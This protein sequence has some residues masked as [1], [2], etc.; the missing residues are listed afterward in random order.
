MS[1][2]LKGR[3]EGEGRCALAV[4]A[5]DLH[6]AGHFAFRITH[7]SEEGFYALETEGDVTAPI[8]LGTDLGERGHSRNGRLLDV[9]TET[10][11]EPL[12]HPGVDIQLLALASDDPLRRIGHE[13]LVGELALCALHFLLGV[14]DLPPKSLYLAAAHLV[15]E[16]DLHDY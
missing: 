13:F 16:Q 12:E 6:E 1:R 11:R 14:G 8:Q 9:F 4:R 10:A 5:D 3:C 15:G 7:G 2:L